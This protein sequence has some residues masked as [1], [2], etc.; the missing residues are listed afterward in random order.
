ME[1]KLSDYIHYYIGCRCLNTWFA[2]EHKLCDSD[3]RLRAY[4]SAAVKP[5]MLENNHNVTWTDSIKPI[6]RRLE[7][8]TEEEDKIYHSL[9]GIANFNADSVNITHDTP[10]SFH[11][12]L[13]Q[14][15]DL[16]S[17]IQNNLAVDGKE[18]AHNS[19]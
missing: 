10:E 9:C 6:L 2:I 5:Y 19:K 4:D 11:Y 13:K 14:G 17:L 16:F 7:D 12:L 8:M 3:W 18:L 15:F 1:K